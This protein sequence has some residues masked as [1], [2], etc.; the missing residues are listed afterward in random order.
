MFSFLNNKFNPKRGPA[1]KAASLSNLNITAEE[2]KAEFGPDIKDI[3]VKLGDNLLSFES[4][5]WIVGKSGLDTDWY[6]YLSLKINVFRR[7]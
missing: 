6:L 2:H 1:R 4:G 7:E 3:K 5:D